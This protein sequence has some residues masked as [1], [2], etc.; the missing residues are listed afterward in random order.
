MWNS[1]MITRPRSFAVSD[2]VLR[3]LPADATEFLCASGTI[4]GRDVV[5]DVCSTSAMSSGVA[6]R[7]RH[8]RRRTGCRVELESETSRA[9]LGVRDESRDR[10]A[11]FLGHRIDRRF[12]ALGD[13][14]QLR[15]EVGE[16]E[17]EFIGAIRRVERRRRRGRSDGQKGG[18]HLRPVVE[19]DADAVA[20]PMP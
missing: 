10:D 5:P 17:L 2:S 18:R 16:I 6:A 3:M 7:T 11:E 19:H 1:G 20:G 9:A 8:G 14:E 4:F 13:D 15:A 12:F